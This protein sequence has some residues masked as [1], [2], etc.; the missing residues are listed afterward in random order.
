MK[1]A[2]LLRLDFYSS[3]LFTPCLRANIQIQNHIK[4]TKYV[5]LL[6]GNT[7]SNKNFLS[8]S[9]FCF[10]AWPFVLFIFILISIWYPGLEE[11]E[12]N[13]IAVFY[14]GRWLSE[15]E[16]FFSLFTICVF[17]ELLYTAFSFA[18]KDG[19]RGLSLRKSTSI[20]LPCMSFLN[21]C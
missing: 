16:L 9:K 5:T 6:Q 17:H 4:E 3:G 13:V 12:I 20:S 2:F 18:L 15:K 7:Q 21:W 10:T 8:G 1:T 14:Y 11:W 19:V